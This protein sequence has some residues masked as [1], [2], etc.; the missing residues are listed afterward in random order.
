MRRPKFVPSYL[1]LYL[2]GAASPVAQHLGEVEPRAHVG[3]FALLIGRNSSKKRKFWRQEG[4]S[5]S[6]MRLGS[7]RLLCLWS[8]AREGLAVPPPPPPPPLHTCPCAHARSASASAF[9]F[10]ITSVVCCCPSLRQFRSSGC[11]TIRELSISCG[12]CFF[13]THRLNY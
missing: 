1:Y 8:K 4:A 6:K 7:E 10:F 12:N 3:S 13:F 5:G 9:Y 2:E 11:L